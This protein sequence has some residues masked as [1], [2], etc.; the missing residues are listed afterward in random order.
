MAPQSFHY[1]HFKGEPLEQPVAGSV[2]LTQ[3]NTP[4]FAMAND[5]PDVEDFSGTLSPEGPWPE[6]SDDATK[7]D[8]LAWAAVG[9]QVLAL[10]R[11][12]PALYLSPLDPPVPGGPKRG[13]VPVLF[14]Q[15]AQHGHLPKHGWARQA[16]WHCQATRA[17]SHSEDGLLHW[18]AEWDCPPDTHPAW[19][20]EAQL[21]HELTVQGA[22]LHSRLEVRNTG[23][24]TFSWTGGLHPYWQV[25]N[26]V[27]CLLEGLPQGPLRWDG[28]ECE[29]L[30]P[31]AAA[32]TLHLGGGST[33]ALRSQG[34]TE[35]MVWNPGAEGAQALR[36]LPPGDWRHFVCIEPVCVSTPVTLAPGE[37]FVGHLW[38]ERA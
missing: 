13:G 16:L 24:T 18:V 7:A 33:L 1:Y 38:V 11:S 36:D 28:A 21:R 15:F 22:S 5:W 3:K 25:P 6:P 37:S 4:T 35:W 14:P 19:P 31:N 17:G 2:R 29:Q 27:D 10:P 30:H 20:H 9:G 23:T 34:F 32:L 8:G 26:V 12:A